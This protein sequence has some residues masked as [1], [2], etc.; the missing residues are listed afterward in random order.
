MIPARKPQPGMP[1]ISVANDKYATIPTE[2][3]R[4][5]Q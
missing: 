4:N 2:G 1:K 3:I 5:V